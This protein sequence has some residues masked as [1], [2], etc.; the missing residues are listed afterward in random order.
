MTNRQRCTIFLDPTVARAL[1]DYAHRHRTRF[2]TTSR[3]AEH[4][5]ARAL[6]SDPSEG[7]EGLLAPALLAAVH[8]AVK[9]EIADGMRPLLERQG[10]RLAGLLVAS[11][12]DA[13]RAARMTEV[14]LGHLLADPVRAARAAEEARLEA[15]ARYRP[16]NHAGEPVQDDAPPGHTAYPPRERE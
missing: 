3:A 15:G 5:L 7:V 8:A 2:A 12:K 14:A 13:H 10:E 6:T 1:A 9:R 4:L 16:K 11:G